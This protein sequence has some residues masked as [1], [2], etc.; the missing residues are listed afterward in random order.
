MRSETPDLFGHGVWQSGQRHGRQ[1]SPGQFRAKPLS[2]F[3]GRRGHIGLEGTCVGLISIE[4]RLQHAPATPAD[5]GGCGSGVP[6]QHFSNLG[7]PPTCAFWCPPLARPGQVPPAGQA[8]S[9]S[10]GGSLG[11]GYG[12][13]IG[14]PVG[15]ALSPRLDLAAMILPVAIP[16]QRPSHAA[17]INLDRDEDAWVANRL[18]VIGSRVSMPVLSSVCGGGGAA[19]RSR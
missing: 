6:K 12:G 13:N 18:H 14:W 8:P 16:E 1:T 17:G 15:D 3:L 5:R 4:R 10:V 7:S 9:C 11:L 2:P 19:P